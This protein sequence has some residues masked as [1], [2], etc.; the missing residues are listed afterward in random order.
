MC[1]VHTNKYTE[2]LMTHTKANKI[3]IQNSQV[4]T[5]IVKLCFNPMTNKSH[6]PIAIHTK[7]KNLLHHNY[8]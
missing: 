2:F 5:F 1:S 4:A 6:Y 3:I 8:K 7:V